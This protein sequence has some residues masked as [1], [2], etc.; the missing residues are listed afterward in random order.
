MHGLVLE[1]AALLE[2]LIQVPGDGFAFAVRIG[3]KMQRFGFFQRFGDGFDVTF[4]ALH[5][6]V[7]HREAVIGVDRAFLR[8]QVAHVAIGRQHLEILAQVFLDG[9][10]FG[11]RFD[12]Y[13][14]VSHATTV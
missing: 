7:L 4:I 13:Q 14:I 11:R 12:D 6:L 5:Q 1:F 9:A 2:D 10:R 8:H 3:R